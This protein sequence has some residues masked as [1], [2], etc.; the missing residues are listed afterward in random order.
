MITVDYVRR[1]ALYNRWRN[2]NLYGA[3]D[4]MMPG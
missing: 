1:M 2:E 3:A 4:A